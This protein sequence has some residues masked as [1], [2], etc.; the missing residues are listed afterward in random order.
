MAVGM[1][2]AG[3]IPKT[4]ESIQ[5]AMSNGLQARAQYAKDVRAQVTG[6]YIK[7]KQA[8]PPPPPTAGA[9]PTIQP[10]QTGFNK[11]L[12]RNV[13]ADLAHALADL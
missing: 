13:A 4:F 7:T 11:E 12:T 3:K 2:N 9:N 1:A 6:S 8:A 10:V 5:A